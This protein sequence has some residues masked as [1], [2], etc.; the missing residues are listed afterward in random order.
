M[1]TQL[2]GGPIA[3]S[4]A[5]PSSRASRLREVLAIDGLV[6][7]CFSNGIAQAAGT[8]LF[9]VLIT[10]LVL[11]A[12]GS[13]LWL[14]AVNAGPVVLVV[15][16]AL[17]GGALADSLNARRS[18]VL[19]RSALAA[20]AAAA[21]IVVVIGAGQPVALLLLAVTVAGLTAIDLPFARTLVLRTAG[22]QRLQPATALNS[23]A[24]NL[25]N[26]A[27]PVAL[28]FLVARQG[29]ASAFT[30]LTLGLIVAV[31]LLLVRRPHPAEQDE[32]RR[33]PRLRDIFEGVRYVRGHSQLAYL[34]ALAYLVPVGGVFFAM[35]P[36]F[37]RSVFDT[38]VEGYGVVLTVYGAGNL[39]GSTFM[40]LHPDF[41]LRGRLV[42]VAGVGYGSGM[43]AFAA[44]PALLVAAVAAFAM[45]FSAMVW[46]NALSTLIQG[47]ADPEMKGRVMSLYTL[48]LQLLAAGWLLAAGLG[49][50]VEPRAIL[51]LAGAV[52]VAASAAV[53]AVSR[54]VRRA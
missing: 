23:V 22:L 43:L 38:G 5:A 51:L 54:E 15:P 11:E 6:P 34:V 24:L 16:A 35:A 28:T 44:S 50:I 1:T 52:F 39:C 46:Q 21:A 13:Q 10:W 30:A 32:S 3:V 26:L 14:A 29:A 25:V 17:W 49:Q 37:V 2:I 4:A 42:T 18:L 12:T 41:R 31:T 9:T 48:A 7:V 45:G 19:V 53:Y 8:R 36:V 33:A 27:G 20:S 40:A 47:T